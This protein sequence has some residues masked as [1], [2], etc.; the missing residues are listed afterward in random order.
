VDMKF[1]RIGSSS[2]YSDSEG[3]PEF[4]D[5]SLKSYEKSAGYTR[6]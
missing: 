1:S 3:G 5:S 4:V 6:G 2:I